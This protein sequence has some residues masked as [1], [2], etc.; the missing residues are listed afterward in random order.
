MLSDMVFDVF[1]I[2][3]NMIDVSMLEIEEKQMAYAVYEVVRIINGIPL[4][5]EDHIERLKTSLAST[6][7]TN[8]Q[9]SFFDADTIITHIKRLK[10]R[11]A[12]NNF[13]VKLAIINIKQV[14]INKFINE[15][16]SYYDFFANLF[17]SINDLN[18][19]W[20][21]YISK[22]Y[23]PSEKELEQ[24]LPVTLIEIERQNPNSKVLKLDY[25]ALISEALSTSGAFEVLLVN[26]QGYITEGSRSNVFF[27]KNQTVF[28]APGDMVLKGI[29][30][31]Y[32]LQACQNI[33]VNVVEKAVLK[34]DLH[35]YE[36]V[37]L[38]GTSIKVQ[39][40]S[41]I[42]GNKINSGSNKTIKIIKEEFDRIIQNYVNAKM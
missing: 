18:L 23:Y 21:L 36:G 1:V 8:E 11:F 29:T 2:N 24:G 15:Q 22:S 28:T 19:I 3:G 34:Q 27:V 7:F 35:S 6:G 5:L 25:K 41:E 32:V 20:I 30:R 14:D 16:K 9:I 40:V 4:F 31:K 17:A 39:P 12:Q 42:D 13:N 38:S 10:D 37:F 33:G 26:K